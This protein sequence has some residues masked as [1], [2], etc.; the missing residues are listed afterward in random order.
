[1]H[2][3]YTEVEHVLIINNQKFKSIGFDG[4][5]SGDKFK[6]NFNQNGIK[7]IHLSK[8]KKKIYTQKKYCLK[9]I[10][11]FKLW[12]GLSMKIYVA[13]DR[14]IYHSISEKTSVN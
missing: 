10:V 8:N 6:V 2:I 1:M 7:S 12:N 4:T 9:N 14:L 5:I 3:L 11:L 13:K